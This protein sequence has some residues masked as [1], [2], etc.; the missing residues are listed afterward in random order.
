MVVRAW[1]RSRQKSRAHIKA[2]ENRIAFEK[3][4]QRRTVAVMSWC[5]GQ[6]IWLLYGSCQFLWRFRQPV[7]GPLSRISPSL[8]DALENFENKLHTSIFSSCHA[9]QTLQKRKSDLI[10]ILYFVKRKRIVARL[11]LESQQQ[12]KLDKQNKTTNSSKIDAICAQNVWKFIFMLDF[13]IFIV[14]Q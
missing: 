3:N 10:A 13:S 2:P 1:P 9:Q 7:L 8:R 6:F 14:D 12:Q 5:Y 4:S 11:R